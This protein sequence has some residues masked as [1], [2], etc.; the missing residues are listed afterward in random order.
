MNESSSRK[1]PKPMSF[2]QNTFTRPMTATTI[3]NSQ[4][5]ISEAVDLSGI[6]IFLKYCLMEIK[7]TLKYKVNVV[8]PNNQQ[9]FCPALLFS[10]TGNAVSF[11][12]LAN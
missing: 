9:F 1:I 3:P 11:R 10:N 2:P 4:L 6:I 5:I 8:L 12:R 7:S